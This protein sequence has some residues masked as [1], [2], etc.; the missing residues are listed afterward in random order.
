MTAIHAAV[1]ET[2]GRGCLEPGNQPE[3]NKLQM[4]EG[5]GETVD[6]I[7]VDELAEREGISQFDLIKIDVEGYEIPTIRGATRIIAE[8]DPIIFYEIKEGRHVHLELIDLFD[9]LGYNSYSFCAPRGTLTRFHKGGQV[10]PFALN[11]IAVRP[12]SLNRFK[13]LV[14][15]E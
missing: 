11:M 3:F 12:E 4:G 10:D 1:S 8:N 2:S 5:L 13:G 15:I 7:S 9:E 14:N 6:M